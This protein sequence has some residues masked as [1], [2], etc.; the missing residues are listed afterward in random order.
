MTSKEV[1]NQIKADP[2]ASYWL[3]NAAEALS[4]RD[5]VDAALDVDILLSYC[6]V[7]MKEVTE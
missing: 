7:R 5:P 2:A 1:L 6:D 4:Q 3:K